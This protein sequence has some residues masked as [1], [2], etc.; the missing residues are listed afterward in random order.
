MKKTMRT[1]AVVLII[2]GIIVCLIAGMGQKATKPTSYSTG[3][4]N[5]NGQYIETNSGIMGGNSKT[6][7]EMKGFKTLGI[8]IGIAGVG[9]FIIS[10]IVKDG[11]IYSKYAKV[12]DNRMTAND[13]IPALSTTCVLFEFEDGERKEFVV[14][15]NKRYI[16]GDTGMLKWQGKK[17][18][19]FERNTTAK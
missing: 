4:V 6:H 18:L 3:Y 5:S 17:L 2:C 13:F 15:G 7:N 11:K 19:S 10:F 12:V 9:L 16:V 14:T 8:V 1:V